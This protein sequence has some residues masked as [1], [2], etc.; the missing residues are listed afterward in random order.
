MVAAA[1]PEDEARGGSYP[2][3]RPRGSAAEERSETRRAGSKTPRGNAPGGHLQLGPP[4][5]STAKAKPQ[6]TNHPLHTGIEEEKHRLC[7]GR[8]V[9]LRE[10]LISMETGGSLE[11]QRCGARQTL[12]ARRLR[13]VDIG[14]ILPGINPLR[15]LGSPRCP[16]PPE[17]DPRLTLFN[18][19]THFL[20]V[21][22]EV[23]VGVVGLEVTDGAVPSCHAEPLDEQI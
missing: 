3:I 13:D 20:G 7:L 18:G 5:P 11:H 21:G 9:E 8:A 19:P 15:A 23:E 22:G 17:L 1:I 16:P 4:R 2:R 10:R 6:M 14:D 12:S